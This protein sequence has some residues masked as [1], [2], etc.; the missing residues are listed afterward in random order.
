MTAI[1]TADMTALGTLIAARL[2]DHFP[3]ATRGPQQVLALAEETGEFTAAYRRWAGLARRSGTREE[4]CA[5]LA[6]VTITAYVTA[7][8]LGIDL[9]A[10]ITAKTAVIFARGWRDTDPC[11]GSSWACHRCGDAWF[12]TPPDH[13]LCDPCAALAAPTL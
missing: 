7:A 5:E 10:A 13:G 12:S 4:M 9:D 3:D 2:A 8:V 11:D 6:D 1:T